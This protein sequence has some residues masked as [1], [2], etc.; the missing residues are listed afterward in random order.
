[1]R[2][3][4]PEGPAAAGGGGVTPEPDRR[5]GAPH[6]RETATLFGHERAEARFLAALASGRLH[7]AWLITGPPGIGKATLAWRI[8]RHL[9]AGGR[10]GS[11]DMDPDDAVFRQA[12]ALAAPGLF[13]CRR[14]WDDKSERLRTAITVDEMRALTAF[15]RLSAAEGGWRV[16]IVDAADEMNPNAAN[17]LLKILEEPPE[18]AALILVCHAPARLLPTIRSRCRELAL[19]PLGAPDLARA[20]AAIGA[21]P[22][23]EDAGALTALAGGSVGAAL[24]L[25]A[26]GGLGLYREI[27]DLLG[28]APAIDRSR[29]LRFAAEF[30]GR[31][32]GARADLALDLLRTALARLA[33]A[34]AGSGAGPVWEAEGAAM[35]RLAARPEQARIWAEAVPALIGRAEQARALNLDPGQVILDTFLRIDAA[36]ARALDLS[37]A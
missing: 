26:G 31:E 22:A 1:M 27:V 2:V 9:L 4:P 5:A 15:F 23:P 34:A 17:A 36:A 10:G 18:R 28:T 20:L 7:H 13:L 35:A 16:A 25:D 33:L 21:E 37:A 19:R 14:P 3:P 12:A 29:L 32:G 6:P 24:D 11:L 30:A 8:A